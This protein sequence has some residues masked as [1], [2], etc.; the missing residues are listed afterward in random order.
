[1]LL[2]GSS[3]KL[4]NVQNKVQFN[5]RTDLE[6]EMSKQKS[7]IRE[8]IIGVTIELIKKY[9]DTSMITVREIA[10]KAGV[11]V[12]LINYHFQTK[13]N[14][15]NLC[16]MELIGQS[17]SQIQSSGQNAEKKVIDKLMELCKG[18]ASFM[19]VNPG[20]SRISITNDLVSPHL[21]DNVAMLTQM[22][23]PIVKELCGDKKDENELLILLHMLI[24]SISVGFLRN[25]VI[26]KTTRTDFDD[27]EQRDKFVECCIKCLFLQ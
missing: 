26:S 7:K 9:G 13:E 21:K 18:I 20:L 4:N 2:G 11:G 14:L 22:L 23:L 25:S 16:I 5:T 12:G 1:M 8:E 10:A 19:A 27:K 6:V 3:I 15:I 17:I 24:S